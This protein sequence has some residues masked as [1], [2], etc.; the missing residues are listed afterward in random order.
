MMLILGIVL[1]I[2][3]WG[4]GYWRSRPVLDYYGPAA[5]ALIS[6]PDSVSALKLEPGNAF[7]DLKFGDQSFDIV[8]ERPV[9]VARGYTNARDALT[10]RESY[11]WSR[12]DLI[13]EPESTCEPEWT[14]A[15]RFVRQK[16]II[17]LL[18][19]LECP[20]VALV[21]GEGTLTLQPKIAT[22]FANILSAELDREAAKADSEAAEAE[23]PGEPAE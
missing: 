22:A 7:S 11:N 20:R 14:H 15:L 19:S 17:V 23:P 5:I 21:G 6:K 3:S 8:A 18:L 12:G 13:S 1:A 4:F 2:S 16:D 9:T 10:K